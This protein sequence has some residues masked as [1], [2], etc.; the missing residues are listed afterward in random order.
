MV[1]FKTGRYGKV[2]QGR[3]SKGSDLFKGLTDF[4]AGQNIHSGSVAA[5]GAVISGAAGFYRQ[6]LLEYKTIE[7]PRPMEIV[8]LM[9]NVSI[10]DG[11]PFVH[12]HIAL[13]DE[14][15]AVFGGHLVEGNVVFACE[16]TVT[17]IEGVELRRVY[18]E[19]TGLFL[20]PR[21]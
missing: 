10:K 14:R 4:C 1:M 9:G 19:E 2:H 3:L 15:G 12:A 21:F 13:M 11:K 8:S 20:W 7:F 5:I 16:F 18:D 6:D 17:E